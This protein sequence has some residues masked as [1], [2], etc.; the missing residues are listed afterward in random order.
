MIKRCTI[1][2]GPIEYNHI[3]TEAGAINLVYSSCPLCEALDNWNK[4]ELTPY[5]GTEAGD[6]DTYEWMREEYERKNG[7]LKEIV[8]SIRQME[9][10]T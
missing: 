4:Y 9:A 6:S 2:H 8:I 10:E 3:S 5:H 7:K 1:G